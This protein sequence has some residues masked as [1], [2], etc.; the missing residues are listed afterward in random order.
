[1]RAL[2]RCLQGAGLL[3]GAQAAASPPDGALLPR[4]VLAVAAPAAACR[5]WSRR[6]SGRKI[7][8]ARPADPRHVGGTRAAQPGRAR[9]AR[10]LGQPARRAG[11]GGDGDRRCCTN[12]SGLAAE[13]MVRGGAWMFLDLGRRIERAQVTAR[14]IAH[15]LSETPARIEPGLRL[16]LELCDLNADLSLPLCQPGVLTDR[17]LLGQGLET[18]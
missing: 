7:R 10:R 1:M 5:R 12:L 17:H 9:Q 14:N 11:G 3:D 15:A 13:N 6:W 8:G 16:A 18:P 4:A 2:A